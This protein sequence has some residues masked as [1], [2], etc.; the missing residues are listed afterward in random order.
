MHPTRQRLVTAVARLE[1]LRQ[2]N[3][4]QRRRLVKALNAM[5]DHATGSA[6]KEHDRAMAGD[7]EA[8]RRA[9]RAGYGRTVARRTVA[10]LQAILGDEDTS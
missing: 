1:A 2:R 3:A 6:A 8:L 7:P 5:A 10:D 4:A 9:R